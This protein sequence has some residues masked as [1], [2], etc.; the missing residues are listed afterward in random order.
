MHL[1]DGKSRLE[2]GSGCPNYAEFVPQRG[3]HN[4]TLLTHGIK[5]SSA[6]RCVDSGHYTLYPLPCA[7][8]SSLK[9]YQ[10]ALRQWVETSLLAMSV[11]IAC[12]SLTASSG[13]PRAWRQVGVSYERGTPIHPTPKPY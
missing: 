8:S 13:F 7:I 11:S 2:S 6:A 1:L 10:T 9:G 5:K 3:Y 4:V 12:I